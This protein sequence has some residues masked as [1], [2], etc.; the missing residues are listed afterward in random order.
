MQQV[1]F[2]LLNIV[3]VMG[4][5][6]LQLKLQISRAIPRPRRLAGRRLPTGCT[7]H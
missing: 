2:P 6:G 1:T 5:T 7:F 3:M 4:E